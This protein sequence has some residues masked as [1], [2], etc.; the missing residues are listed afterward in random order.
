MFFFLTLYFV[1]H[2]KSVSIFFFLFHHYIISYWIHFIG[3]FSQVFSLEI[4]S[5]SN[6]IYFV[7][8]H[9]SILVLNINFYN[10]TQHGVNKNSLPQ[11]YNFNFVPTYIFI[12]NGLC[13]FCCHIFS[14]ITFYIMYIKIQKTKKLQ[15]IT[16]LQY[17]STTIVVVDVFFFF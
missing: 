3:L 1:F 16:Y 11:L 7:S 2:L 13:S 14:S 12:K 6:K 9:L 8:I 4:C 5:S 15:L 17:K 10:N